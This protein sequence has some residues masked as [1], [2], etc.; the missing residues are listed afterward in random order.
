MS[1]S[2]PPP[3]YP[4]IP[5]PP[6]IDPNISVA[7]SGFPPPPQFPANYQPNVSPAPTAPVPPNGVPV[8]QHVRAATARFGP[9]PIEMDCPYC[10]NHIVTHTK[11]TAG[12]LP[13]I[14]FGVC[15]V[16]GFFLLIPWCLCCIPF[17]ID[18]C[19]DV[20]HFCPSCKRNVG[21]F[22]KI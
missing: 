8:V 18:S 20:E 19:L 1:G 12:A 21:R 16:L 5:E 13:W 7:G 4:P 14:I 9:F 3:Y 11:R 10:R 17:C 6:K 2:P 22:S 15:V